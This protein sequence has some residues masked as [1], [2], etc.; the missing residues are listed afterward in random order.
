MHT[1]ILTVTDY[2]RGCGWRK[3]GGLYLVS[4]GPGIVCGRLP[5][6]TG[7]CPT[8]GHGIRPARSFTWVDGSK[9]LEAAPECTLQECGWCPMDRLISNG[10]G[11]A[12]LIWIGEKYYPTLEDFQEEAH[13]YGIS[14]RLTNVPNDFVVGETWVLLAHRKAI[15]DPFEWGKKVTYSPGIFRVWK[16]ERIEIIVTGDEPDD[17]IEGYLAR[18]LTPVKIERAEEPIQE[19]VQ[20]PVQNPVL[21]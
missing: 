21:I 20:E 16:P 19:P 6:P 1:S 12:G 11:K 4:D 18:G 2:K 10:I 9:F 8:C 7:T 3:T 5:I 13:R 14:R 15:L 17:E